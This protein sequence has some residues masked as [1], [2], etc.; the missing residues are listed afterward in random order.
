MWI[1]KLQYKHEVSDRRSGR[2]ATREGDV[3]WVRF[4]PAT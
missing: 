4:P 3:M 2:V 1:T